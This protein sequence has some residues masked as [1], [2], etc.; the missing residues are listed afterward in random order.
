MEDIEEQKDK[1]WNMDVKKLKI[2]SERW[3]MN[4]ERVEI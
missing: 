4:E 2:E 1:G 3:K